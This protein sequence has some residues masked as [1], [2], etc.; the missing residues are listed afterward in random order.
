L[1][2]A[3]Y[4]RKLERRIHHQRVR[5]R[6]LEDFKH[7]QL[8]SIWARLYLEWRTGNRERFAALGRHRKKEKRPRERE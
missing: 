4:I 7:A 5:L 3:E 6:Q 1:T 8:R 2:E